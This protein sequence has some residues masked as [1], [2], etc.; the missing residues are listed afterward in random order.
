MA[1][2]NAATFLLG[3]D[4]SEFAPPSTSAMR[5]DSSGSLYFLSTCQSSASPSKCVTK[6]SADGKTILWQSHLGFS[7]SAL[8]VDP[9]GGVYVTGYQLGTPSVFLEK[10]N[11]AGTGLA[12]KTQIAI[13][14]IL[15]VYSLAADSQ[16][17]VYVAGS[18]GDYSQGSQVIRVNAAGDAVDYVA[19]VIGGV[20]SIAVD[21]AG[22]AFVTGNNTP[23]PFLAR[24]TPNGS[25]GFY[26]RL[27]PLGQ[28]GSVSVGPNGNAVALVRASDGSLLLQRFDSAGAA[29]LSTLV[30][31]VTPSQATATLALDEIGNAYVTGSSYIYNDGF[32]YL[33]R[34]PKSLRTCGSG[35]TIWEWLQVF[36][37]DGS[38]LQGTYLPPGG[39]VVTGFVEAPLIAAGP[40]STIFVAHSSG[41]TFQ[42]SQAGPF[43][44]PASETKSFAYFLW[45]LFPHADAQVFRL[46]CLG[47]AAT[48]TTGPIAP[49]ELV[50]LFGSDLGP[51]QGTGS[52]VAP[53][54][55]FPTQ[56]AGVQVT[57]DGIPSPLL[58]VQN[59]QINAVVPWSLTP[60]KST[61]VCVS[62]NGSP[63]NCLTWPVQETAV[64]VFSVDGTHAVFNQDG[65]IN[66]A[67]NP[68]TYGSVVT[69]FATG[70]GP[71]SPPQADGTVI[72]FPLP[73]N[74]LQ[75]SVATT[76]FIG[77]PP[78]I[79]VS[80]SFPITYVGPAPYL[81]AGISRIDFTVMGISGVVQVSLSVS[82]SS[83]T[84]LTLPFRVYIAAI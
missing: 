60:G 40:N 9:N 66:S 8:A 61:Q 24:L 14:N 70:L 84:A 10:L 22:S 11:D 71:I 34:T 20:A 51:E 58:W 5:T 82:S 65:S 80:V 50:T 19:H 15:A 37:P 79:P 18:F 29:T 32:G 27:S 67:D 78:V 68:A 74:V 23:G 49:G 44:T 16:G 4:Y 26:T 21:I 77:G 83:E 25:A 45:R 31:Y 57:F 38:L 42:P 53:Q 75:A 35:N 33:S 1:S 46:A 64:S 39:E 52:K 3:A 76:Y 54:S 36:S 56:T 47:S 48:Y 28:A 6:L 30:G 73:N 13:G 7:P 81:V 43:E 72:G 17:R 62:V 12:W 41:P 59:A 69:V 55:S 2:A 63:T